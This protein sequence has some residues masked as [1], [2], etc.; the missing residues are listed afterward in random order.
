MLR[1]CQAVFE[2]HVSANWSFSVKEGREALNIG[3]DTS[4]YDL[5]MYCS[6][7]NALWGQKKDMVAAM[8]K[9]I[10]SLD[11]DKVVV[12]LLGTAVY[13]SKLAGAS[14]RNAT[15][16]EDARRALLHRRVRVADLTTIME[17]LDYT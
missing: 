17:T 5:T 7:G 6:A 9:N 14:P 3:V 2:K 11:P 16:F 8:E 10:R 1:Y 4:H 13:W 15:F 12:V